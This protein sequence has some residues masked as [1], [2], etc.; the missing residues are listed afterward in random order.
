ML[1]ILAYEKFSSNYEEKAFIISYI[2]GLSLILRFEL[3]LNC[4]LDDVL[5]MNHSKDDNF[6]IECF[7]RITIY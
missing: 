4:C 5:R 3:D 7:H 6:S 2:F 1:I